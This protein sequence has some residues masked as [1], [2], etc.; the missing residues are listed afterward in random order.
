LITGTIVRI[1]GNK[2]LTQLIDNLQ[3]PIVMFQVGQ[4]M[5]RE[6]LVRSHQD[7]V[8]IADA[9]LA[10][11]AGGAQSIMENHLRRSADWIL[12][13]PDPAFQL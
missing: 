9:I 4:S 12:Q 10:G 7:H 1:G 8:D 11:D 2:Q 3:L 13:L 5:Q 6:N